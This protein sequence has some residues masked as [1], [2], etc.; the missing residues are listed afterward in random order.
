M[1][2]PYL[3]HIFQC[4]KQIYFSRE[5]SILQFYLGTNSVK[6]VRSMGLS[7]HLDLHLQRF[8]LSL[9]VLEFNISECDRTDRNFMY[10]FQA[11]CIS[12]NVLLVLEPEVASVYCQLLP[13]GQT[14]DRQ[15]MQFPLGSRFLVLDAGGRCI[16]AYNISKVEIAIFVMSSRSY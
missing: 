9:K 7:I 10:S 15:F 4:R 16:L 13:G 12:S 2:V 14:V 11:G 8:N 5:L 1:L 3:I 6:T